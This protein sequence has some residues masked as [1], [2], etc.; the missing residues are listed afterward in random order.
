MV[1]PYRAF[2]QSLSGCYIAIIEPS[3]TM[4]YSRSVNTVPSVSA[5]IRV[6]LTCKGVKYI[7]YMLTLF[8]FFPPDKNK[9]SFHLSEKTPLFISIY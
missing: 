7:S 9:V 5:S 2:F 6:Y 4:G 3:E 8:T 1:C